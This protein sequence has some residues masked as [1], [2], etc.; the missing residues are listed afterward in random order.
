MSKTALAQ[1]DND[2]DRRLTYEEA[3]AIL[4]AQGVEFYS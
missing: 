3:K 2:P 1:A 4:I